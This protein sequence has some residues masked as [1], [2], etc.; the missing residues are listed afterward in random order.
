[1]EIT[2]IKQSKGDIMKKTARVMFVSF[3]TNFIL[4]IL[5]VVIGFISKSSALLADG[6]HSFSDLITDV[7]AILGSF[8][9]EKPEDKEHPYGHG[10]LEYL[11]S[12]LIGILVLIIGLTLIGSVSI[13]KIEIPSK[14]VIIVSMFTI[15]SKFLLS[16]YLIQKGRVYDNQI[17]V[18]SGKESEADV[19]SSV[20][21]LISSIL[22]Q[23]ESYFHPLIYIDKIA[24]IIVGIFIVKAGFD[25]IK[26]N[27]NVLI[28]S[29]EDETDYYKQIK[30]IILENKSIKRID[31][32]I[33]MKYG[34][35]YTLT[36]EVSMDE[37]LTLKEAHD[38]VEK[39]E[40]NLK[41][42]NE[43]TKYINIHMN[44]YDEK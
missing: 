38:E 7:V 2:G 17:L 15:V 12:I 40:R 25:I 29:Q 28:G 35:Y 23:F 43:R 1:M 19:Y 31:S 10:R 41:K 5:K 34:Y 22:I 20:I 3:I 33:A 42:H 21:V 4:S 30:D 44:P 37:N 14:I 11:T 39:I 26:E 36:I 9:S 27:I 8:L 16:K 18:S 13:S 24:G 32:L 6:I